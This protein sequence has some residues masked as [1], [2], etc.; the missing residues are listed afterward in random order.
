MPV[1][2]PPIGY[3]FQKEEL[4]EA[5]LT[6]CSCCCP[7]GEAHGQDGKERGELDNQRLE[8]LGDAVLDLVVSDH[9][10]ARRPHLS[11]GAMSRLRACLV[12]E[13]RLAEIARR[14]CLGQFLTLSDP[15]DNSGGR[16]KTSILADAVEAILGAVFL[17]GGH[18]AARE[19]IL[20]LWA[21][22]LGK[23]CEALP[24][25]TDYKTALQEHTQRHGL[26]LPSYSLC[27]TKGP[28][29]QPTF[30]MSVRVGDFEPRTA[31]ARSKKEAAQLAAKALLDDILA[32]AA[33]DAAARDPGEAG[34]PEPGPKEAA[35]A[36][37]GDCGGPGHPGGP[38]HGDC[39]TRAGK[40]QG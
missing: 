21:P 15:E 24:D 27:G 11:E 1:L 14:L 36:A 10:F 35:P 8:F 29:H 38:G 12:C 16:D 32:K 25:I 4:L 23:E 19:L 31:R 7:H 39:A 28:A 18:E 13:G 6:H 9:L 33:A 5:A 37:P 20:R 34:A 26:G 3:T 17:D 30:S 22:Y 40:P 2:F